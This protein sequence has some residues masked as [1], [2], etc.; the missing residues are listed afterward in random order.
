M[1]NRVKWLNLVMLGAGLIKFCKLF[2][3]LLIMGGRRHSNSTFYSVKLCVII[4]FGLLHNAIC[5]SFVVVLYSMYGL[6]AVI[7]KVMKKVVKCNKNLRLKSQLKVNRPLEF[8][9]AP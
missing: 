3:K 9:R 7:K 1:S 2:Q 6:Y 5:L 4:N 8:I